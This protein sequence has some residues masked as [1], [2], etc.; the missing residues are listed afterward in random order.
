M[1]EQEGKYSLPMADFL[2]RIEW[3]AASIPGRILRGWHWDVSSKGGLAI[4]MSSVRGLADLPGLRIYLPDINETF[5]PARHTD[6]TITF[7]L[8][9]AT[10]RE[11]GVVEFIRGIE[12]VIDALQL[13]P[14]DPPAPKALAGTMQH[15]TWK[16]GDNFILPNSI[17]GQITISAHPAVGD[18]GNHRNA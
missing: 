5:R 7:A 6:G 18:V 14:T 13:T 2:A 12:K 15:F 8:L 3:Q 11:G 9:I 10:A 1:P 16:A 4:P 17:N